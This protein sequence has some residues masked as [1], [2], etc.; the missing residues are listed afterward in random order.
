MAPTNSDHCALCHVRV[1]EGRGG[2]P[3]FTRNTTCCGAEVNIHHS[4]LKDYLWLWNLPKSTTIEQF[5]NTSNISLNCIECETYCFQCNRKHTIRN[6]GV[7]LTLCNIG[8]CS[9]WCWLSKNCLK[10]IGQPPYLCRGCNE[11]R[12]FSPDM[13]DNVNVTQDQLSSKESKE[14]ENLLK[15][16][17]VIWMNLKRKIQHNQKVE[18][19]QRK[20]QIMMMVEIPRQQ[21]MKKME[22]ELAEVIM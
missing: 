17:K 6:A 14:E 11:A 8:E 7:T 4:C 5:Q 10:R 21:K 19:N 15:Q 9:N 2:K 20:Q 1:K 13:K 3:F 16:K 12:E 22:K 18:M